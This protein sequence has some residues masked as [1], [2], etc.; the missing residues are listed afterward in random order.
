MIKNRNAFMGAIPMIVASIAAGADVRVIWGNYPTASSDGKAI[1]MPFLPLE[2]DKVEAYALGFAVHETG[3]IVGTDFNLQVGGGLRGSLVNILED[4]RIEGERMATL[5]G[6]RRWLEAL[7]SAL[8][9]DGYLGQS[10]DEDGVAEKL[11]SYLLTYLWVEVLQFKVLEGAASHCRALLANALPEDL[12]V[13]VEEK[14]LAVRTAQSTH[15][16]LGIADSIMA[17]LQQEQESA[18]QAASG[19]RQPEGEGEQ[20]SPSQGCGDGPAEQAGNSSDSPDGAGG[21][22]AQEQESAPAE[23]GEESTG[24]QPAAHADQVDDDGA[25]DDGAPQEGHAPDNGG[26]EPTDRA[27]D[28]ARGEPAGQPDQDGDDDTGADGAQQQGRG[29]EAGGDE[30]ADQGER[31]ADGEAGRKPDAGRADAPGPGAMSAEAVAQALQELLEAEH[32]EAGKDISERIAQGLSQA[33]DPATRGAGTRQPS[34]PMGAPEVA[35]MRATMGSQALIG[36]VRLQSMA[37]RARLD[38]Y[39]QAQT[40]RRSSAVRSGGRLV[41]NA[42]SRLAMKDYR[43]YSVERSEVKKVDTAFSLLVDCSISMRGDPIAVARQAAMALAVALEDIKGTQ[44][45]VIGFGT[46]DAPVTRVTR[47]GESIRRTAGRVETLDARGCSTPLAEG[48]LVA[49]TDLLNREAERRIVM[50][51]TDGEPND[52]DAVHEITRFGRRHGI[53][54][55]GIGICKRTDHL[56]PA[57]CCI[58]QVGELPRAVLDM[59]QRVLFDNRLAA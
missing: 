28:G 12:F 4:V 21:D 58:N 36:Q 26:I 10:K 49:H 14:A 35:E 18:Q 42:A 25:D 9:A 33:L 23:R 56:F 31:G 50:V 16:V 15:D 20:D 41:R 48:L 27:G 30:P 32:V 53:E 5:P 52:V 40:R 57:S 34:K 47:F 55:M 24:G 54:H 2:D 7:A 46:D 19:D 45:S 8:L 29:A 37:L 3:H 59:V 17:L 43:I 11:I 22:D 13:K 1:K 44:L 51:V 39:V 6:A 38:E